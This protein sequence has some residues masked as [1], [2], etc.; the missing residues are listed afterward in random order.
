MARLLPQPPPLAD[1]TEPARAAPDPPDA[2]AAPA[3]PAAPGPAPPRAQPRR[4]HHSRPA[5]RWTHSSRGRGRRGAGGVVWRFQHVAC[6]VCVEMDMFVGTC[7]I[8]N[9]NS[10]PPGDSYVTPLRN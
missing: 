10:F 4:L 2:P 7:I 9:K 5:T 1:R 6:C 3:V 8:E